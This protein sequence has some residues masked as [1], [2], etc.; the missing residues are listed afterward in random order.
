[1]FA[2]LWWVVAEADPEGWLFGVPFVALATAASLRLTP[3]RSWRIRP[4]GVLRYA[5]FFVHQSVLGGVDVALRAVR[6]SMPIDP[7]LLRYD[8]RLPSEHARVLFADT[9][10]ML[11]G[12]LST[13]FEGDTLT[14]HA[15]DC[16]LDIERSLQDVEERVAGIFG[17]ELSAEGGTLRECKTFVGGER[18]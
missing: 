8:L 1:M 7:L 5:I 17:L 10:S 4:F 13:G 12:T 14:L 18:R 16:R 11:P 15:I 6:P 3:S 9:V 2:L